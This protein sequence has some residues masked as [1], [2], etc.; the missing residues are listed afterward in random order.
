MAEP[1]IE[2]KDVSSAPGKSAD[3]LSDYR[4]LFNES[5]PSWALN[6]AKAL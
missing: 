3:K 6:E 5:H 4:C 1:G 2:S